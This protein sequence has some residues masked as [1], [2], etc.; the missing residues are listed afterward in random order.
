M[1][2]GILLGETELEGTPRSV[3]VARRFVRDTLGAGHPVLDDVTLLV[4]E[5][6]TNALAH[7][8]SGLDG[9]IIRVGIG[10]LPGRRLHV[11]VVDDGSPHAIPRPRTAKPVDENGR[12]LAILQ[13][14]AKRWGTYRDGTRRVVWFQVD[15]REQG[16]HG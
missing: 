1:T 16:A 8:G 9:G 7:S 10:E 5:L 2:V 4:S 15:F 3:G 14:V 12:G 6:V 11:V 13:S